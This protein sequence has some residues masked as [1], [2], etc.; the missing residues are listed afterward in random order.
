MFIGDERSN[1]LIRFIAALNSTPVDQKHRLIGQY[2]ISLLKK[3]EKRLCSEF[4]K[5]IPRNLLFFEEKN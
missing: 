5:I 2:F 1:L 3:T 4:Q